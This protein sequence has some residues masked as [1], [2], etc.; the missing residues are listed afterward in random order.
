MV[1]LKKFLNHF[2]S[3]G[4]VLLFFQILIFLTI[5]PL[6]LKIFSLNTLMKLLSTESKADR[7][8]DAEKILRLTNLILHRNI[9]VYKNICLKRSLTLYYFLSRMGQDV[10]I[11]YGVKKGEKV[12]DE[13]TVLDGHSWIELNGKIFNESD[14][15]APNI[16]QITYSYPN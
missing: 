6:L 15:D 7:D 16:Y 9:L 10:N 14:K 4:D 1:R 13:S 3:F 5:L 11:Y 8:A 12:G 2:D